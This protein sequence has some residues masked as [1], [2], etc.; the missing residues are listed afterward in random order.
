MK[1]ILIFLVAGMLRV[2]AQEL[3][4]K[5]VTDDVS[6]KIPETFISM[7]DGE[8]NQKF[9]SYRTPIAMYTNV[10]RTVDL[11]INI[12]SSEW[13][14]GDLQVLKD[15]YKSNILNLY[16]EVDFV[17]DDIV[18]IGQREFIV[19]EFASKV[20][21][22]NSF[23]REVISKY[24]YIQYTLYGDKVLLFHFSA[25]RQLQEKWQGFAAEMM[26]SVRIKS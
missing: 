5:K 23:R 6:M 14:T 7:T 25:P 21:E 20:Y 26:Q 24:T 2:E 18:L 13:S 10:E 15:F 9:I 8:R 4:R 22:E 16:T 3:E 19:F 1:L 12:T 17:Q 11:G